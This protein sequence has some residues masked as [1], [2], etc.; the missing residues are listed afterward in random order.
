[1]RNPASNFLTTSERADAL[2]VCS[3]TAA[4]IAVAP[5]AFELTAPAADAGNLVEIQVTPAGE[6][7]PR[8]GRK[9][10]V[11]AWRIDAA[12]AAGVIERFRANRTPLVVD[13]EHQTLKVEENGQP[14]PAAGFF[15]DLVWREGQG[16]FATVELT[17]RARDYVA[18]GEYRYF[19]PVFAFDR[20]T[21]AVLRLLMGALTNNPALDGMQPIELRAAARFALHSEDSTMNKLLL[22]VC[23]SLALAADTTEEQAI[24]ALEALKDREDPL[25]KLRAELSLG[26]DASPDQLVAACAGLKAKAA[27]VDPAKYAPV[28][29]LE[30]V[31]TELAALKATVQGREVDELVQQGLDD[32]RLLPAQEAWARDLGK[33]DIAALK[34]YLDKTPAIA[35][36]RASQTNGQAPVQGNK[37]GLNEAEIAVCK[38]LGITEEQ[39]AA[40]KTGA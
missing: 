11:P 12:V 13:Y 18:G 15:R 32:G 29:T 39:F 16:L 9:I 21:G 31:K 14:A 34:S 4:H 19:S 22:A 7:R 3:A 10:D 25:A 2:A 17:A 38:Q 24:A 33:S 36:L 20:K 8:D 1:M 37:H 26:E 28:E 40:Q 30:A 23:T 6:F 5:C 35:A 27:T